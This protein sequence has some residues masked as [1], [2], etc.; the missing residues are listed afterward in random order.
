MKHQRNNN[1]L[2]S[3]TSLM[4]VA[5]AW[6][7]VPEG[8]E[9]IDDLRDLELEASEDQVI[10]AEAAEPAAERPLQF[11]GHALADG[12]DSSLSEAGP[13]SN[14]LQAD[15]N[16]DGYADLAIGVPYDM[17]DGVRS[18]AV[19]VIYGTSHG[20]DEDDDQLW[21]RGTAGIDGEPMNG[22][23]FGQ[24]L[25]AGD[26][27]GDGYADLAIGAP[28]PSRS[29]FVHVLYGSRDGLDEDDDQLW[30]QDS[31]GIDG[32]AAAGELFGYALTTGDFDNDGYSD[33]VIGVPFDEDGIGGVNIIYGTSDGLDEDDDQHLTQDSAGVLGTGEFYDLFGVSLAA[34]D[35]DG[36]GRDDL[37]IGVPG[38]GVDRIVD[39][40]QVNVLY[41][42]SGGITTSGDEEWHQDTSGIEGLA[43]EYDWFG[44]SLAIGD[45]DDDGYG[46]LAVG[47][48]Y[49]DV[50]DIT[51]AGAVN[52]IYGTRDGL[53]EDDDQFLHQD[54]PG[55]EGVAE[56]HDNFG[57]SLAAA[58]FDGDD[59]DDLAIG[60]PSED[61]SDIV[62][63]GLVNVLYGSSSGL[64]DDDN[65]LWHQNISGIDGV[66]EN[67]DR[68]G[69]AVSAG[70]FDGDGRADMV[71]GVPYEDVGDITNAGAVNVIY[72]KSSG[73]HEDDDQVF[74][75]DSPGI[76]GVAEPHENFGMSVR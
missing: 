21:H 33:L 74:H 16:G 46:D 65:E 19:N 25:A 60:V 55:I 75:Q 8:A 6:A 44:W 12:G 32:T 52:V 69:L 47:V 51:N 17:N 31:S 22:D 56:A 1:R 9:S 68:F 30:H 62:N 49:E 66:A 48:P 53:D 54:T 14:S 37:A 11:A 15:F 76:D 7:C 43:E 24:A 42:S 64:D 10:D 5:A 28:A 61:L 39:A 20:L 70:D 58:N 45:F 63:A 67:G 72:G 71:V 59:E 29:G 3:C 57:Y 36:D 41:G 35:L 26:F 4:L 50:G 18:G 73:L 2:Y 38:E 40:G 13:S 23:L 34:G 27:N